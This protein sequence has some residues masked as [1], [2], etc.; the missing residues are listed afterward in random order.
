M[1]W[2]RK[3][4]KRVIAEVIEFTDDTHAMYRGTLAK[5]G[6]APFLCGDIIRVVMAESGQILTEENIKKPPIVVFENPVPLENLMSLDIETV[7]VVQKF[8]DASD[9]AKN[10]FK[11]WL[12]KKLKLSGKDKEALMKAKAPVWQKHWQEQANFNPACCRIVCISVGF[13]RRNRTSIRFYTKSFF[14]DDQERLLWNF[15]EY[16]FESE[17]KGHFIASVGH[18]IDTF[19]KP[20]ICRKC[21]KYAIPLPKAFE[22]RAQKKWHKKDLHLDSA[23]AF[24]GFWGYS[25]E[26]QCD[27]GSLEVVQSSNNSAFRMIVNTL[28]HYYEN[29]KSPS[30]DFLIKLW[31]Y[32]PVDATRPIVCG[33][34]DIDGKY[35][36]EKQFNSEKFTEK[37]KQDGYNGEEGSLF[38]AIS[39]YI[40]PHLEGVP[41]DDS[42]NEQPA[43]PPPA[44]EPAA[45]DDLPF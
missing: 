25:L 10:V 16:L 26:A 36:K 30:H 9:G 17:E 43:P 38:K 34:V 24:P 15:A 32:E 14:G 35:Y 1:I 20:L 11:K 7:P 12:P 8:K 41:I 44:E 28:I 13:L 6:C 4:V 18:S 3:T 37:C 45:D 22:N 31:K 19:D 29:T 5:D 33:G 23:Y 42:K 39:K 21:L 27:L 2:K 40:L